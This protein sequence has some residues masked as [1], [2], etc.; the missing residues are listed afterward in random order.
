MT[1]F[2]LIFTGYNTFYSS[3]RIIIVQQ[4]S[5]LVGRILQPDWNQKRCYGKS[6]GY[7]V[8][9]CTMVLSIKEA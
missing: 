8:V 5:S 3:P 1:A 9:S 4:E 6:I 7:Y 2:P